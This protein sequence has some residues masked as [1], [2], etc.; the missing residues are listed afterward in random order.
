MQQNSV[1]LRHPEGCHSQGDAGGPH[2]HPAVQAFLGV[3]VIL[4]A[5]DGQQIHHKLLGADVQGLPEES[6]VRQGWRQLPDTC[7]LPS[8]L[9]GMQRK[10]FPGIAGARGQGILSFLPLVQSSV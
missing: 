6:T 1:S 4:E 9:S 10:D 5:S 8:S 2:L 7:L 3:P